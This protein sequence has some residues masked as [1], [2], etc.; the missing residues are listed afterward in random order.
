MLDVEEGGVGG[1]SR[2]VIQPYQIFMVL[3]KSI[4]S[5]VA[6][7]YFSAAA[8]SEEKLMR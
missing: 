6:S 2:D 3:S 7:F 1:V 5:V 8:N 4:Y